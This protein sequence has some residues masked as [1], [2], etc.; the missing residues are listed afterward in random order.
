MIR[1][2]RNLPIT[3]K[4]PL[5]R[6]QQGPVLFQDWPIEASNREADV[7][8]AVLLPEEITPAV[9]AEPALKVRRGRVELERRL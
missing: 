5:G 8:A 6:R 9:A 1:D 3:I 2:T 7:I 4:V